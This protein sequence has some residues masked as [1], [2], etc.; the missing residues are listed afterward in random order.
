MRIADGDA[1][2]DPDSVQGEAHSSSPKPLEISPASA[3]IAST[4]SSPSVSSVMV[5]P[6]AA[7]SIITPMMLLAL[8][9]RPLRDTNTLLLKPDASW[10]SRADG[11]ACSPSL[12]T[13]STSRCCMAHGLGNVVD[14][15]APA[16]DDALDKL[17]QRQRLAVVERFQQHRQVDA[18]DALDM[19]G[20][21]QTA[22]RVAG[23]GAVDVGEHQDAV[24]FVELGDPH[25]QGLL[26]L[27]G[28]GVADEVERGEPART[29]PQ[30]VGGALDQA[31]GERA[32]GDDEDAYHGGNIRPKPAF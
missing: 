20:F 10:V 14:A 12:L 5:L 27:V 29:Q 4:S 17:R 31:I 1:A 8:T 11:R 28:V 13:I 21:E 15:V 16:F 7:A 26:P 25:L 19:G 18:G 24:A 22:Q 32:V 30:H 9:R 2:G 23:G 6:L 3:S